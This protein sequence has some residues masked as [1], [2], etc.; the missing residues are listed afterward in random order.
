MEPSA[1]I[2][3][4]C[5]TVTLWAMLL[6]ELHVVLDHDHRAVLADALQQLGGQLALAHAHAGDRLVE[7]QQLGVLH[8][9]HADFQPLLLAVREQAGLGVELVGQADVLR[10]FVD[11]RPD[12]VGALEGQRAEH[13]AALAGKTLP[14]SRRR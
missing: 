4:W 11:A 13:A 9:Q 3:P 1:R 7:H 14:G 6:D 12:L 8:Q 2:F 5:I 10:H